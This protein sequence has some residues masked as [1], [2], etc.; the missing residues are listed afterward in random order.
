MLCDDPAIV[1]PRL[2]I[3]DDHED[4]RTSARALLELEG[5]DVVG[6]AEDGEAALEAVTALAPDIVLLDIQLPGIDG[7]DVARALSERGDAPKVVLISSRS[8]SEYAHRLRAA[9]V[10]GFLGKHELTGA[11]LHAL[12]A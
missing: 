5:F 12:V 9:P 1:R 4:F 8:G 11:A 6:L 3:V 2:L 7:F 10:Q